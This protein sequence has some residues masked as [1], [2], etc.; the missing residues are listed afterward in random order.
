MT[1]QMKNTSRKVPIASAAKAARSRRSAAWARERG[2]V[3]APSSAWI[4]VLA[5][6]VSLDLVQLPERVC[7][8]LECE[9][10]PYGP[11]QPV[12]VADLGR[13]PQ[14]GGWRGEQTGRV[15]LARRTGNRP[16]GPRR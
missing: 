6:S 1:P 13:G 2:V 7:A 15:P 4:A 16:V 10:V 8:R 5:M 3:D 9:E 12:G 11:R 14:A